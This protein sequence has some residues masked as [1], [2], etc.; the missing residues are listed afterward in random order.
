MVNYYRRF[1]PAAAKVLRPL[2]GTL[3]GLPPCQQALEWSEEM[4]RSF[5]GSKQLLLAAIPLAH[6][7]PVAKIV[8][9]A[10]NTHIGDILQQRE[11][12]GWRP[13]GF[14]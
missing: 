6:P 1:L 10:S 7:D 4:Q 11:K 8:I 9:A 12:Y 13:L 14:F 3:C 2:T 5:N